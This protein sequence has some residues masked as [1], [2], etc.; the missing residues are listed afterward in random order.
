MLDLNL[1]GSR[2]YI[3]YSLVVE[4]DVI[5]ETHVTFRSITGPLSIV[6]S[7]FSPFPRLTMGKTCPALAGDCG[8]SEGNHSVV[9]QIRG[10]AI[11]SYIYGK[12][13]F[14][15]HYS[16][17]EEYENNNNSNNNNSYDILLHMTG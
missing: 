14:F 7:Y 6:K 2:E 9:L 5:R 13:L 15:Y 17:L 11:C 1:R 12:L 3:I 16:F 10:L 4:Y 8:I